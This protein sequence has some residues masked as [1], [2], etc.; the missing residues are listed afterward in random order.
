MTKKQ[1]QEALG[2]VQYVFNKQG[3]EQVNGAWL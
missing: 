1:A 2:L 3:E